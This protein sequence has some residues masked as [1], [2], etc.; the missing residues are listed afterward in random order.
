MPAGFTILIA[1]RNRHVRNF[2]RRELLKEGYRVEVARDGRDILRRMN[3]DGPP[4]LLILDLEI[5]YVGGLT[6]LK[7]LTR[8]YPHLPVI[9]HTFPTE[10]AN[11]PIVQNAA[12]FVEKMGN[13]DRLKQ[14]IERV[15]REYYP[16][17][18]GLG[19]EVELQKSDK[20]I[21]SN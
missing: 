5:P 20:E 12:A 14:E 8:R 7:R 15:L 18:C 21:G 13:T 11:D 4:D 2:L 16:H 10:D 6:I 1:D 9:I 17:R 19:K 3:V